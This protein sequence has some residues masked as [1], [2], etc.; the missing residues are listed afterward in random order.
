MPKSARS[1]EKTVASPGLVLFLDPGRD[2]VPIITG[3]RAEFGIASVVFE[4]DASR[5]DASVL[6][7][8]VEAAQ[9]VGA[10]A[11]IAGDVQLARTL[12]A[13]GVHLAWSND[14]AA[15]FTEAREILGARASIGV[16][17]G[18]SRHDAMTLAEAG[19][20]YIAF[21]VPEGVQDLE[22]ARDRRF[23]LIS[24]WAS[25]FEVPCIALNTKTA[26]DAEELIAAGADF[27]ALHFEA[28]IS[29]EDAHA[30]IRSIAD[31]ARGIAT[32]PEHEA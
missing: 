28:A 29:A 6:K 2:T 11:L 14:L 12:R 27:L 9:K 25:I 23:E 5:L 8:L 16:H 18:K 24:W 3:A 15:R 10:A 22:G 26:E 13:D 30:R 21:G 7:P 19:A 4:P 1:P 31:V 17:G 20:D 32:Q